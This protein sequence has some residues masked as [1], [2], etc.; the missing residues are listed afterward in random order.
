MDNDSKLIWEGV[1]KG[2][3]TGARLARYRREEP[4]KNDPTKSRL[5]NRILALNYRFE[6]D[7][8]EPNKDKR[9]LQIEKYRAISTL[10]GATVDAIIKAIRQGIDPQPAHLRPYPAEK[11]GEYQPKPTSGSDIVDRIDYSDRN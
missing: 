8:I 1:A 7:A 4:P 5:Y 11:H 3:R 6:Q 10:T 2:G 9:D